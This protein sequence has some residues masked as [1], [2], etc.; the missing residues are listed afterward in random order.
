MSYV[1]GK[2]VGKIQKW[3]GE[4]TVRGCRTVTPSEKTINIFVV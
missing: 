2:T 3:L 1:H 4:F